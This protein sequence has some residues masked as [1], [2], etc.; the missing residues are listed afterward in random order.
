MFDMS[1]L[2]NTKTTTLISYIAVFLNALIGILFTPFIIRSL[3][4]SQYGLYTISSS[5]IGFFLLDFGLGSATSRFISRY[6]VVGDRKNEDRAMGTI[7]RLYLCIDLVILIIL[8]IVFFCISNIY[9]ALTPSEIYQLK[10]IF[11]ISSFSSVFCFPFQ[12]FNGILTSYEKYVHIKRADIISKVFMVAT[13]TVTLLMNLGLYALV[14]VQAV[15]ALITVTYKAFISR[16]YTTANLSVKNYDKNLVKEII[17]F[18]LWITVMAISH[19][20]IFTVV[21]SILGIVSNTKEAAH[22]SVVLTIENYLYLISTAFSGMFMP[23]ISRIYTQESFEENLLKLVTRVGKLIYVINIIIFIGLVFL[24]RDF[25]R[26]W[27]GPGYDEVHIGLLMVVFPSIFYNSMEVLNTA[28]MVKNKVKYTGLV[29]LCCGIVNIGLCF[30]TAKNWG[31]NGACVSIMVATLAR[32][33]LTYVLFQ[34]VLNIN[35]LIIIRDVFIRTLFVALIEVV[36]GLIGN[37]TVPGNGWVTL[38]IRGVILIIGVAIGVLLFMKKEI[39]S[40]LKR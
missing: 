35:V 2:N 8:V 37:F 28:I 6:H 36:F 22:F 21:P 20:L 24:G 1:H 26:L 31:A 40:V 5:L 33:V 39:V 27:A 3:G 19:R 7:L 15:S 16:K 34:C 18:S 11:I 12:I 17:Q 32:S 9:K 25:F 13:I 38:I 4:N 29:N 30:I 10:V 23:T 14:I